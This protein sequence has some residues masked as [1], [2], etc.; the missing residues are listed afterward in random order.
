MTKNDDEL[1]DW[2]HSSRAGTAAE[3]W[4]LNAVQK[5][6]DGGNLRIPR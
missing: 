3:K 2:G 6:L 4:N 5:D 1:V